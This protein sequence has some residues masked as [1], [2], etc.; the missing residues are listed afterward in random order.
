MESAS[1]VP[2]A[3]GSSSRLLWLIG[4]QQ[5]EGG[6]L[7]RICRYIA[8]ASWVSEKLLL[9]NGGSTDTMI[10]AKVGSADVTEA[11]TGQRHNLSG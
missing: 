1:T 10:G 8:G 4:D 7:S 6:W 5:T 11:L 9:A 3:H 2:E